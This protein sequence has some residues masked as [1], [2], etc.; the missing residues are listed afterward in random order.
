MLQISTVQDAYTPTFWWSIIR[1]SIA[2]LS[3]NATVAACGLYD[4]SVFNIQVVLF[5]FYRATQNP[6]VNSTLK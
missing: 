5:C 6:F 2:K 4:S 1:W 3:V